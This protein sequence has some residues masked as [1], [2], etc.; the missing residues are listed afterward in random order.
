MSGA[1]RHP[2][3]WIQFLSRSENLAM[4]TSFRGLVVFKFEYWGILEEE[5]FNSI[6]FVQHDSFLC[7]LL[8]G[9]LVDG[10]NLSSSTET[11]P[12]LGILYVFSWLPWPV[13]EVGAVPIW[14]YIPPL[15]IPFSSRCGYCFSQ[16][17]SSQVLPS[18]QSCWE[19]VCL[20]HYGSLYV[21]W[22]AGY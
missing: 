21:V 12:D 1:F 5:V 9:R 16:V 19:P 10:S 7:S 20:D 4:V 22:R 18:L 6:F 14:T 3:S 8:A 2:F 15:F 11:S 17:S 13:S